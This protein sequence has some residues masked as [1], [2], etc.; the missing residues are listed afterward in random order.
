[1]LRRACMISPESSLLHLPPVRPIWSDVDKASLSCRDGHEIATRVPGGSVGCGRE[2]GKGNSDARGNAIRRK[3]WPGVWSA[4]LAQKHPIS[5]FMAGG[6][7]VFTIH[8]F[9]YKSI[10]IYV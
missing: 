7:V 8:S 6:L 3:G 1:V 4:R 2:G 5:N 9:C 10:Y